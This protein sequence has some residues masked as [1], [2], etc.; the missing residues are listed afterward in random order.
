M[1][2]GIQSAHGVSGA[3]DS[4]FLALQAFVVLF[5][6]FHDWVPLGRLN[7][8]GAIQSEDSFWRRV[9]VTLL[10]AVPAA[11]GLYWSW[12]NF[13]RAYPGG[14]TFYLWVT[15]GLLFLGMLRAWWI[16][17]L[18]IPD[19]ERAARYRIL[20][21]NTHTFLPVRNGL[22]P[23][24]LHVSLHLVCLMILFLLFLRGYIARIG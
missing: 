4:V 12:I 5:L 11:L 3:F 20:F 13:D 14:V 21:K 24:S 8:L 22:A 2:Q 1:V 7:N 16:P 17:Y 19:P 15:Y 23:D 9:F 6:L 18:L 10:P